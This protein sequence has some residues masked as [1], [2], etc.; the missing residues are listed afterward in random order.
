MSNNKFLFLSLNQAN[1]VTQIINNPTAKKILDYLGS[2]KD[3]TKTQIARELK[4]PLST[5]QY[6]INALEKSQLIISDKYHYSEKGKEVNHYKITNKLIVIAPKN[7]LLQKAKEII[8]TTITAFLITAGIYF[9]NTKDYVV[10]DTQ[11][12]V[13][14]TNI[15]KQAD[16]VIFQEKAA[17]ADQFIVQAP[18]IQTIN[19]AH[20]F[21]AGIITT[22]LLY[23]LI[24]IIKIYYPVLREKATK[25][26][27][28]K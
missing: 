15:M 25:K 19:P 8:P 3:A 2:K 20:Y 1:K 13:Q 27:S 21:L 28:K 22:I 26:Y 10:N 7:G 18:T 23:L 24:Q 14:S 9:K 12:A 5:V 16:E 11:F 6:N 17:I 4:L